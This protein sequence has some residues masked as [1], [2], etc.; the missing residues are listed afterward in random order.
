[1]TISADME[2]VAARLGIPYQSEVE[3]AQVDPVLLGRLPLAFARNNLILPLSE[4]E[5]SLTVASANPANF[6]A[7]D[8]VRGL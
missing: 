8:E 1:M 7:L 5:G 6:A 2:T 3:D 4:E